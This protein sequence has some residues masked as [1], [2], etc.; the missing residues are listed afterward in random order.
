MLG[1]LLREKYSIDNL[2]LQ[3]SIVLVFLVYHISHSMYNWKAVVF[4]RIVYSTKS[5]LVLYYF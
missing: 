1:E 4:F 2:Q 5:N 3:I